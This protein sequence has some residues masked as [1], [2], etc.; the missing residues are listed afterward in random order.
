MP[1]TIAH[2]AIAGLSTRWVLGKA[3]LKWVYVASVVPDLPWIL[4]RLI[5]S[6]PIAIDYYHLRAYSITQSSLLF[7]FV[8]GVGIACSFYGKKKMLAIFML[9]AFVHLLLDALQIK[10]ANGVQF[11]LPID[12]TLSS[13]DLFW[14]ES[15]WT[16]LLT[17][18][19]FIYFLLNFKQ[20]TEPVSLRVERRPVFLLVGFGLLLVWLLLPLAFIQKAY[21]SDNH[22][23]STLSHTADRGGKYVEFDRSQIGE[24]SQRPFLQTAFN[25]SVYLNKAIGVEGDIVSVKGEFIDRS[26][27]NVLAYHRHSK[28]RDRASIVGLALVLITW[29]VYLLRLLIERWS[30]NKWGKFKF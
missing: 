27:I 25:E 11:F 20:T 23:I 5:T 13:F 10:W 22:Y 29:C 12:W 21:D 26:T 6:S 2:F 19:G 17:V 28:F 7:S 3:D 16:Y 4:Q 18:C 24:S 30:R 14:P 1:N 15:Y 9:G 8:F